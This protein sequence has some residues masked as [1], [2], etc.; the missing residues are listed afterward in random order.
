[1]SRQLYEIRNSPFLALLLDLSAD[2]SNCENAVLHAQYLHNGVPKQRFLCCLPVNDKKGKTMAEVVDAVG[3]TLELNLKEKLCALGVDG[4]KAMLGKHKGLAAELTKMGYKSLGTAVHCSAHRMNLVMKDAAAGSTLLQQLDE[5]YKLVHGLF[6]RRT[7]K[8]RLWSKFCS[9]KGVQQISFP[10]FNTTRW[11][12]RS[13][14]NSALSNKS[15]LLTAFLAAFNSPSGSAQSSKGAWVWPESGP[16]LQRLRSM[17]VFVGLAC[18]SDLLEP[19]EKARKGLEGRDV[20]ISSMPGKLSRL[21]T[22]LDEMFIKPDL[23]GPESWKSFGGK[24]WKRVLRELDDESML[25]VKD[26]YSIQLLEGDAGIKTFCC[27]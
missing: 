1:M 24:V 10:L 19:I 9:S 25:W 12:S 6:N 17:E 8:Y 27:K 23:A 7:G 4:D 16:V 11:F 18:V 22:E 20:L 26:G 15:H 5:L 13:A 14:C 21:E 2:I 3:E